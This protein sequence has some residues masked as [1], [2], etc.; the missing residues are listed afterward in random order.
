MKRTRVDLEIANMKDTSRVYEQIKPPVL[1][2][3]KLCRFL[4]STQDP[5]TLG[6]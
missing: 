6:D 3:Y 2:G 1:L 4:L 5:V